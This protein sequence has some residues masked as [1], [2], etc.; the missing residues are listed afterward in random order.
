MKGMASGVIATRE[1]QRRYR[2]LIDKVKRTKMP[3][4]LGM[5]GR[6]EAVLLDM[7]T[8]ERMSRRSNQPKRNWQEVKEV[9]KDI[10]KDGVKNINL[11]RFIREDRRAHGI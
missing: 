7:E 9:L 11:A 6:S 3:L 2:Q 4:Y 1:I 5:R 8:F 10:Q